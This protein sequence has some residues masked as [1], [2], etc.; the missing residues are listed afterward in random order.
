MKNIL[1]A[2]D[3][4]GSTL[5]VLREAEK[6]AKAFECKLWMVHVAAPDPEFAGH[7]IGPQH[8]RDWR[9]QTLRK[10]HKYME[11]E[12]SKLEKRGLNVTPLLI[13]GSTADTILHEIE[14]LN[15]DLVIVGSHGH[16][17]LHALLTDSVSSEI[18]HKSKCPV[19]IVP[20]G[21]E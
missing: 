13:Q 3:F 7:K 18:I 8:E 16:G 15:I 21:S 5:K 19:L 4:S 20:V 12:A 17:M 1:C 2:I 6:Y 11:L 14:K 10:E 9:A